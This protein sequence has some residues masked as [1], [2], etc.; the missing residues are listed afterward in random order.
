MEWETVERVQKNKSGQYR[1]F[2]NGEWVPVARAQK[3]A[4]GQFRV[5]RETAEAAPEAAPAAEAA[6]VEPPSMRDVLRRRLMSGEIFETPQREAAAITAGMTP[7]QKSEAARAGLGFAAGVVA[8]PIIGG[9]LR[10]GAAAIPAAQRVAQPL[11]TAIESGGF[12]SGLAPSA[13]ALA[14]T[15]MRVAGGA[16]AGGTAAAIM[17][18]EAALTGA[19]IG[20]AVPVAGRVVGRL[21]TPKGP[22]TEDVRKAATEAYEEAERLGGEV[23]S[24]QFTNLASRLAAKMDEARFNPVLHPRVQRAL[25]TFTTEATQGTPVS[26]NRLDTLRRVTARAAGSSSADEQR[27]GKIATEE[28]DT[29][30]R[31]SMPDASVAA[32]EKARDLWAKMSRSKQIEQLIVKA[33]RSS[34]EPSAALR[35]Q[36]QR[37]ADNERRLKTF[38][39]TEQDLIKK[40]ADGSLPITVLE[41]VGTLAP[42]RINELRTL[43]GALGAAGYGGAFTL[44]PMIT[45]ATAGTGY[46]SRTLANQMARVQAQRLAMQARTG[47]PVPA[48]PQAF[49]P[50]FFPQAAPAAAANMLAPAEVDF[51][52]EQQRVNQL[53]R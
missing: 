46:A 13:P 37:L 47:A 41:R 20:G 11:A 32:L 53:M 50:S 30:I 49:E 52:R 3:N 25:D 51:M 43:P 18:P 23:T 19:A 29:F 28:I 17:E 39:S 2:I 5:M 1:A 36:F 14:Q 38:S 21:A 9:A 42:P 16:V 34:K 6:A 27:L 15:G 10:L 22:K 40:I 33:S 7:E 48:V 4:Q 8:G 45:A 31:E 44:N 12:R 35:Q 26:L 24:D